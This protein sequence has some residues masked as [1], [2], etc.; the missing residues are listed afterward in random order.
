MSPLFFAVGSSGRDTRGGVILF[1]TKTR[2]PRANVWC[3]LAP[4]P[5]TSLKNICDESPLSC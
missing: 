2:G 1:G 5:C 3:F 4:I